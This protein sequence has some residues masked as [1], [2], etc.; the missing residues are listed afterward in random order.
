M[1]CAPVAQL[2]ELVLY[3][4]ER[5]GGARGRVVGCR[6]AAR[7]AAKERD[8]RSPGGW[9]E[10][11]AAGTVLCEADPANGGEDEEEEEEE[12]KEAPAVGSQLSS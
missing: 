9:G 7:G 6:C 10:A 11:S 1:R 8:V 12:E 2:V 4:L 5:A 3:P